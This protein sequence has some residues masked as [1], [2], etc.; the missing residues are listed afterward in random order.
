MY[1]Y[2]E[3]KCLKCAVTNKNNNKIRSVES[4]QH[5]ITVAFHRL[6]GVGKEEVERGGAAGSERYRGRGHRSRA[7]SNSVSSLPTAVVIG[8]V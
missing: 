7:S 1:R 2:L 8:C 3:N 6:F 4:K 5:L